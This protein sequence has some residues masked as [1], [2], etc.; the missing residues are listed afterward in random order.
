MSRLGPDERVLAARQ[1]VLPSMNHEWSDLINFVRRS[2]NRVFRPILYMPGQN[3]DTFADRSNSGTIMA[4]IEGH[5]AEIG[6]RVDRTFRDILKRYGLNQADAIFLFGD[7]ND[8]SPVAIV[9]RLERFEFER[10]VGPTIRCEPTVPIE[11]LAY[12]F[13][14]TEAASTAPFLVGA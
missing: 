12:I 4:A 2:R 7:K 14:G 3:E 13:T 1:T 10:R 5:L 8:M 11:D 6:V 9:Q